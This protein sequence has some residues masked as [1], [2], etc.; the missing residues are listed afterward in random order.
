LE[1]EHA[2]EHAF[3]AIGFARLGEELVHATD[4]TEEGSGFAEVGENQAMD[5]RIA[6]EGIGQ[7]FETWHVLEDQVGDNG[8]VWLLREAF[9]CRLATHHVI[10]D[11]GGTPGGE[12]IAQVV[13][14]AC[15]TIREEDAPSHG[16]AGF[17]VCGWAVMLQI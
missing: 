11:P 7:E 9:E 16:L 13:Q 10:H 2:I 3:E 8:I 14:I 1:G 6:V 4:A 17:T 5:K 15:G 12:V